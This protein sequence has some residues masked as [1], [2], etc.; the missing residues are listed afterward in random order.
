MEIEVYERWAQA[1]VG[2]GDEE[3]SIGGSM[4][5]GLFF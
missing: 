3:G 4:L 5:Q 2:W 1:A